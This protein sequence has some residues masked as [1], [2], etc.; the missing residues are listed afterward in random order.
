MRTETKPTTTKSAKPTTPSAT[1]IPFPTYFF[2]DL[3]EETVALAFPLPLFGEDPRVGSSDAAPAMG[4]LPLGER[5][6]ILRVANSPMRSTTGA[7]DR[8]LGPASG[9]EDSEGSTSGKS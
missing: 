3:R 6:R 7:C 1:P 8:R 2:D 5:G 4:G 9:C